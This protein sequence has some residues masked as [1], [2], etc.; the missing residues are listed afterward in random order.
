MAVAPIGPDLNV[1][2]LGAQA[3]VQLALRTVV[4]RL[5]TLIGTIALARLLSPAEF[6]AFAVVTLFV[7]L[8]SLVGDFGMG[9]ALIQQEHPPSE[10]ELSTAFVAQLVLW[11]GMVAAVWLL[12]G[13]IPIV[14]PD[15][16]PEAPGIARLLAVGLLLNGV[17]SIPTVMLTRVLRFGPLAVIE[18]LQQVGYFGVAVV[19]ALADYGVWS[20]AIAAVAQSAFATIAIFAVWRHWVGL[21]FDAGIA[22]RLWGFGIGYQAGHVVAWGREAVI[23]I[24]GGLAGGLAAV[25]ILG[26]AW[27]NGQLVSAVEQ[28]ISRVAFPAFSRLQ[29]DRQRVAAAA[30]ASLELSLVAV[31]VIQGWII[32]TAQILVPVVF[33]DTWIPAVTPLQLVC[34]GSLAGAPTYVLRSYLYA[35][36]ESRR[37]F[38]LTTTSLVVLIVCFPLLATNF[39]LV[40][41]AWSFV[42]SAAVGLLL[43]IWTT[44]PGIRFPWRASARIIIVTVLSA[45]VAAIVVRIVGGLAGVILSGIVYLAIAAIGLWIADPGLIRRAKALLPFRGSA[46]TEPASE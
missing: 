26:F 8:F 31:C 23:P 30:V 3:V 33:S 6:G 28:I 16:P 14:R 34:F 11:S 18:I 12:A 29:T 17:R 4:T 37:A 42:L 2:A 44:H 39:G 24:F 22:R 5:I 46:S 21:R 45:V 40:G 36:G 10:L 1:S 19:L 38:V 43:F 7:T 27:R 25:G 9:P 35:R 13:A 20:F 41:A 32:A 15:L